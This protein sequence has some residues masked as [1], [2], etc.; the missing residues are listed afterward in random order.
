MFENLAG[1]IVLDFTLLSKLLLLIDEGLVSALLYFLMHST[2]ANLRCQHLVKSFVLLPIPIPLVDVLE[3]GLLIFL[4]ALLNVFLLLLQ[5]QLSA[6]VADDIAHAIHDSLNTTSPLS[7]LL[8][9]RD[10]FLAH[11]AHVRFDL[12]CVGL[13]LLLKLGHSLLPLTNVVL[14]NFHCS[15]A[16]SNFFARPSHLFFLK[17]GGEQL[18]PLPLLHLVLELLINLLLFRFFEHDVAH[19]FL[20]DDFLLKLGLLYSLHLELLLGLVDHLPIILG[21]FNQS[22]LADFVP[23]LDLLVEY[24]THLLHS[25]LLLLLLLLDLLLVE[26]LTEPLDLAPFVLADIGGHV[27]DLDGLCLPRD[28]PQLLRG[29]V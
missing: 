12:V 28:P 3:A 18:H 20:L 23:E 1:L 16:L 5:L 21:L 9:P 26:A 6:V 27:F 24:V 7:H 14:D 4:D 29:E 13:L 8:L 15:L 25:C 22:L 11:H 19:L 10:F 17:F 2:L